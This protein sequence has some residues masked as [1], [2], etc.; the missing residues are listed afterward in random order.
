MTLPD[1][2]DDGAAPAATGPGPVERRRDPELRA[3]V[4]RVL[5]VQSAWGALT[6]SEAW[7]A[8]EHIASSARGL[9]DELKAV[10]NRD[11]ADRSEATLPAIVQG[12]LI[13]SHSKL[14]EA[15][16]SGTME[17]LQIA[18][19]LHLQ[20]LVPDLPDDVTDMVLSDTKGL[21]IPLLEFLGWGDSPLFKGLEGSSRAET[22][23]D[24]VAATIAT[25]EQLIQ[26]VRA[27]DSPPLMPATS[28]AVPVTAPTG[29]EPGPPAVFF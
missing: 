28:F 23:E 16:L 14:Q 19:R 11:V 7:A 22:E 8:G 27:A 13:D 24:T 10:A 4:D 18:M 26:D 1:E 9:T 3:G 17:G 29:P 6:G 20:A 5:V 25:L 12:R 15:L 21:H 2:N